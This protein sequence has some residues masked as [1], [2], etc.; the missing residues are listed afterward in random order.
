[1]L[2]AA[3]RPVRH[4]G[5][6]AH[7]ARRQLGRRGAVLSS[8]GLVW[9][10]YGY[11]QISAPQPNQ[12]G[13]RLLLFM[14]LWAWGMVWIVSGSL[15]FAAAWMPGRR[16][17]WGYPALAVVV[18]PW[19]LAYMASWWPLHDNP[20]GWIGALIWTALVV[21]VLVVA[22]WD[23]PPRKRVEGWRDYES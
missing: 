2:A 10:C 1:M 14:P 6:V 16:D 8:L 17:W 15:A 12:S 21:P 11:A 7:W 18:L 4:V 23:E 22:G 19:T 9:V 13:L 5:R 20:R 3:W